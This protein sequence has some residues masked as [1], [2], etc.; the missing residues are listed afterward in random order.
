LAPSPGV[1]PG[2][3][4]TS[5]QLTWLTGKDGVVRGYH[6]QTTRPVAEVHYRRVAPLWQDRYVVFVEGVEV[7]SSHHPRLAQEVAEASYRVRLRDRPRA[8]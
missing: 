5:V 8:K 6:R 3:D 4:T 7:D 1:T 2:P